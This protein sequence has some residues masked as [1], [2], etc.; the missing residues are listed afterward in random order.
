MIF[1]HLNLH[2]VASAA[3]CLSNAIHCMGQ[4]IKSLAACVCL[5]VLLCVCVRTGFGGQISRKR[6]EIEVRLQWDTNRND[7]WRIDWSRDR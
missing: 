4:N 6:L 1:M 2:F 5:C 7:I 3:S